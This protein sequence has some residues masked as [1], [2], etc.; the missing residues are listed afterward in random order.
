MDFAKSL[1]N[2]TA[3][4][5]DWKGYVGRHTVHKFALVE[6]A[7]DDQAEQ[8]C[9]SDSVCSNDKSGLCQ[10][11]SPKPGVPFSAVTPSMWPPDVPE[12]DSG[13]DELGFRIDEEDGPEQ[14]SNKLLGIPFTEDH[15]V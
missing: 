3:M 15:S 14:S 2:S 7:C 6:S 1:F 9:P 8:E 5:N 13:F 4:A 11:V 12:D 10:V